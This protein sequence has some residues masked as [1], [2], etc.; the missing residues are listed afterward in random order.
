MNFVEFHIV[1]N[2]IGFHASYD[3]SFWS[4]MT[5]RNSSETIKLEKNVK[6]L[7]FVFGI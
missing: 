4:Q 6:M 7:F 2:K 1:V 5:T 3:M